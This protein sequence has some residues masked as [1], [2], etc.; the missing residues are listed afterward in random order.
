MQNLF[1]QKANAM[2]IASNY[3]RS[4]GQARGNALLLRSTGAS[5]DG[6]QAPTLS[7]VITRKGVIA[8]TNDARS[9][10]RVKSGKRMVRRINVR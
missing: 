6:A 3:E 4:L 7:T 8:I 1:K 10:I 2:R 5:R 9:V